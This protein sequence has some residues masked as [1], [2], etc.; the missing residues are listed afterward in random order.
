MLAVDQQFLFIGKTCRAGKVVVAQDRL[1]FFLVGLQFWEMLL[2]QGH[3]V[4]AR[5][6]I[7]IGIAK[8][9]LWKL[10]QYSIFQFGRRKAGRGKRRN[11]SRRDW[12][13]RRTFGGRRTRSLCNNSTH[14]SRDFY[15]G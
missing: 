12:S 13:W 2:R 11:R 14:H 1:E 7:K 5:N 15:W 9:K 6:G 8:E 10:V 4:F 3:F